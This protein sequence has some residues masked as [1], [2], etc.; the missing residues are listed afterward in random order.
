TL[1]DFNS[2]LQNQLDDIISGEADYLFNIR[3]KTG[4][5]GWAYFP[6][7]RVFPPD[8]DGLP[9]VMQVLLRANYSQIAIP[10]FEQALNVLLNDQANEDNGWESWIIPKN[11]QTEEQQLQTIWVNKA[12]GTGSDI[13]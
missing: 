3:R 11:N 8:A 2:E 4:I 9:Q 10:Y 12:W 7:L 6:D 5:G 13:E 1:L